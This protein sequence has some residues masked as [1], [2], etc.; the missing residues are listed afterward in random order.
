MAK[1]E[2]KSEILNTVLSIVCESILIGSTLLL[3]FLPEKPTK[4][5]EQ[6]GCDIPS[7]FDNLKFGILGNTKIEKTENLYP[8]LVMEKEIKELN[9]IAN[10]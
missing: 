1:D 10:A 7:N 2:T 9:E 3:P 5:F 6:F 8:R 4:I